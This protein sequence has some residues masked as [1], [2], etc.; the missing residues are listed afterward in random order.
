MFGFTLAAIAAVA[1][2]GAVAAYLLNR[3][4]EDEAIRDAK[5]VTQLAGEGIVEP[6]LSPAL[7]AGDPAAIRHLDAIV[8]DRIL[9]HDGIERV[10]IWKRNGEIIY[11]DEPR[12]IGDN[13]T[14]G[15]DDQASLT[16]GNTEAETTDLSRPEN[17]FERGLGE[18][19][20]VYLPI[21]APDGEPL[22]FETY[23][24]SAFVDSASGR[25]WSTLGPVLI[26]ALLVLAA[27]QL[28]LAWSLARRLRRGQRE[29]ELL[30]RRA[31]D[32]SEMERR[33]IAQD[34]HDG[35]VQDLAGASYSL[36]AAAA[37][38]GET[39]GANGELMRET[40]GRLR[41][42]VRD[43][44]GLLVEIYPADLHRAGLGAALSDV[45]AGI[46]ARGIHTV[47]EVPP[48]LSLPE[49][50][51]TLLLPRGP[52]VDPQRRRAFRREH[53]ADLRC[54][55]QRDRDPGGRG[56]RPGVRP[57]RRRRRGRALRPPHALRPRARRR[58]RTPDRLGAR[59]RDAD[60]ARGLDVIRV[61]IVED[62]ALVRAGLEELLSGA[63][64]I[65]V[66]GV[67]GDGAEAI[68]L[69]TVEEPDVV[70][71][72]LSM[73]VVDGIEATRRIRAA[74]QDVRVVVLTSFSDQRRIL[75]ALDAGAIGYL[76]K[77]AEPDELFRGVRAAAAGEAPLA[78]KAAQALLS[79]RQGGVDAELTQRE[80]E[81][82]GLI[83]AG[84]PN[85]LIARRLEISEKTVKAH[86][87]NI[88]RRIGA[89]TRT[90]AALWA[91]EHGL[92]ASS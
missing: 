8:R 77:D 36:A 14:L 65:E 17:R 35:V 13:Y 45:V 24:R 12:L 62:H 10:K 51:E 2:V 90:E 63:E 83:A 57:R 21:H 23:I 85:K 37:R 79:A 7:L 87:T 69:A 71:M 15:A 31:I 29:R 48:D 39:A 43:L 76:L 74:Q 46:D 84:L 73:P 42:S 55:Q 22:L 50:L 16:N 61:L 86:L 67:A 19:L 52:G 80:Q 91:T 66:V 68:E 34:L 81:V 27:L 44:R 54:A 40:A 1:V 32:A 60:R 53:A 30:L 82:L 6:E 56:R 59:A 58:W 3:A 11:S 33:R 78:P 64:D 88:Y 70:L 89:T 92:N 9:S 4:G 5:R 72:D 18:L 38:D 20:E 47:L 49:E 25:V 26:G 41:Q 75:E 28:P